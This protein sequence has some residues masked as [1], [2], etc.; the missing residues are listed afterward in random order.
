MSEKK[1]VAI[2]EFSTQV[3]PGSFRVVRCVLRCSPE[4]TISEIEKW[5]SA[6]SSVASIS[7]TIEELEEPRP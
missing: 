7:L 2:Y 1:F 3:G 4:T 5:K 6:K